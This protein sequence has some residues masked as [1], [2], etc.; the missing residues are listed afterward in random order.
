M[1]DTEAELMSEG[2]RMRKWLRKA[3]VEA[4]AQGLE[5]SEV[6]EIHRLYGIPG[7]A[8]TS[9]DAFMALIKKDYP[10]KCRSDGVN[11]GRDWSGFFSALS[12]FFANVMPMF[13]QF[14]AAC[15]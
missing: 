2:R 4:R 7:S 15:A 14:F 11:E 12:E 13:M 1:A 10:K 8:Q 3:K 9:Q 6:R 5:W